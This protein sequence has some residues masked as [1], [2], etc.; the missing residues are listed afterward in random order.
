MLA[1]TETA[2]VEE[3]LYVIIL[4]V[5]QVLPQIPRSRYLSGPAVN[6]KDQSG[7]LDGTHASR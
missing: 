6:R 2:A 5:S 1:R 3:S 4:G 7:A